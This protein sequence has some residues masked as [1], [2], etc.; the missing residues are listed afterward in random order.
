[1]LVQSIQAKNQ[2]IKEFTLCA[3][4]FKQSHSLPSEWVILAVICIWCSIHSHWSFK[5]YFNTGGLC[6]PPIWCLDEWSIHS[7]VTVRSIFSCATLISGTCACYHI[8]SFCT[9]TVQLYWNTTDRAKTNFWSWSFRILKIQVNMYLRL[10]TRQC[11]L[12]LYACT[13]TCMRLSVGIGQ[14]WVT[15][16]WEFRRW[17]EERSPHTSAKTIKPAD[18]STPVSACCRVCGQWS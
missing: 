13:I 14:G 4:L 18:E 17:T 12:E 11:M 15:A 6:L 7:S 3:F 8:F 1:M 2:L 9:S 10:F 5:R 16:P